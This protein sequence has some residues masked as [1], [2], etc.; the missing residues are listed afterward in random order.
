MINTTREQRES[1]LLVYRRV[2]QAVPPSRRPITYRQFRRLVQS[3]PG[4][5]MIPFA[6]MWLGIEPDG[7]THS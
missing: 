7:Y 6:G 3:G 4:C 5:I 2:V 1:L